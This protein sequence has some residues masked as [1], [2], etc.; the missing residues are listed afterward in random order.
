MG[1][2]HIVSVRES[3]KTRFYKMLMFKMFKQRRMPYNTTSCIQ[4]WQWVG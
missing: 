2:M 1:S 4:T 3:W